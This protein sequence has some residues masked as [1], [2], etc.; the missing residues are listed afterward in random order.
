MRS[1][2]FFPVM[3]SLFVLAAI[4]RGDP[5]KQD[6]PSAPDA[7]TG[8]VFHDANGNRRFDNN[9]RPLSGI[10]ISNGRRIV[11]TDADGRYKLPVEGDT[12]VFVI[13]PR[14]WRTA[15]NE[16]RLPRFYYIHKPAGSP[17]LK[18]PGVEPTGPLPESIDFPLYPQDEPEQ[19]RAILFGDPQPRD[20][21]EVDYMAHDVVEELVGTDASFG[22]TLGDIVFDDL[23][24]FEPQA[25]VIALLG[26]PWYNVIGNHDINF[27]AGHDHHSDETFERIF[28]PSYYAFDYGPVHFLVLDDVQ[29]LV[30]EEGKGRYRGGL[31]EEQMEFVRN[32]L[33]LI[34]ENQLVVLLMHIPLVDVHDRHQL[35]RLIEK[36]PFCISIS[37]HKH[38]HQHRFI[39]RKDGWRG[40]KPHHHIVNVTVSGS[41][42]QGAA[43]K[44]GIPHTL[45]ADGAP[46]GYSII[47][48]DG[49]RYRLDFSLLTRICG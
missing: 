31:G 46:N 4:G 39:T 9:E 8:V 38:V 19:F 15:H 2:F 27:D 42:W 45:M 28:G 17:K 33:A 5:Q 48:F 30:N 29:W 47:S 10:R 1:T 41:W 40:P 25:R 44:R 3:V 22:V 49:H 20:Q 21:Q 13:K 6:S 43:D 36:R 14:G 16:H 26:I 12:I 18:Y 34:P 24:L 11:K 32:D 37:A 7:A 23:S 35:Y